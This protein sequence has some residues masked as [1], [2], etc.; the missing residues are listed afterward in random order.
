MTADPTRI[1][2]TIDLEA[3][4]RQSGVLAV[5]H[6]DNEHAYGIIGVPIATIANGYG[7]TVLVTAGNH[8]DEHEGPLIVRRLFRELAAKNVRGRIVLMPSLN[9]PAVLAD[10]RVSPVDGGNMNRAYPGAADGTPTFAIAHY[11]ESAL[12]PLCDAALDLHSGGKASEFLPC[13]F[14]VRSGDPGFLA[15]K[16][17]AVQAFGAP[18]VTVVG[19]TADTRSLSAAADRHGVVNMATELGGG[20]TVGIEALRIG[21]E[22]TM[23]WLVH[24]GVLQ[25]AD[26]PEAESSR[27]LRTRDRDDFVMAPVDG[28]FEPA[29]ALGDAVAA[30][31]T[32]GV[33]HRIDDPFGESRAVTFRA[34]GVVV[35][36]RVPARARAGDWL[37]HL[38]EP[39]APGALLE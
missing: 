6:S 25:T 36:R 22:G 24:C 33:V 32:A 37:F 21:Y 35:C 26:V 27:Y 8:G 30:G 29:V 5:S 20:G 38:G 9:H 7:P 23:R 19:S 14:L 39:V 13:A 16:L 12:L 15:A 17:A 4:G 1:S 11:V 28:V 2:C 10:A 34:D 3:P 18:T 31:D